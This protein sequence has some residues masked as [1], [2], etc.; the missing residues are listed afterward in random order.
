[1]SNLGTLLRGMRMGKQLDLQSMASTLGTTARR[2]ELIEA[3][4]SFPPAHERRDWAVR[5]GFADLIDFDRQWRDSWACVTRARR[6]GWLP[7]INQAPAGQPVDYQEYGI[8]SGLGFEYVPRPPGMDGEILF[9]VIVIG[10]SMS[11]AYAP[12]DLVIFRPVKQEETVPDGSSVFVRFSAER[13]HTCTFKNL[14]RHKDGRLEL[15]P[16]NPLYAPMIV[17]PAEIDRLALAVER[18]ARFWTAGEHRVED[19]YAQEFPEE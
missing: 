10:D 13:D 7:I 6:D 11:P 2:L 19:E 1:M 9:A 15:R 14:W 16:Q 4:A 5:L 18:R 8:D 3:G 12:G 17:A